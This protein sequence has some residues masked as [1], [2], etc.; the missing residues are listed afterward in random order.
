[1][2]STKYHENFFAFLNSNFSSFGRQQ[3]RLRAKLGF[4]RQS[5]SNSSHES[6]PKIMLFMTIKCN[7]CREGV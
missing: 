4:K 7:I 5:F 6:K 3:S 1:M 2:A